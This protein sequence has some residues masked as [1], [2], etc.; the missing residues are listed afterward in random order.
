MNSVRFA[1][2]MLVR[3]SGYVLNGDV[4]QFS[5][6]RKLVKMKVAYFSNVFMRISRTK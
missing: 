2:F 4:L 5:G 1:A 6:L 3:R